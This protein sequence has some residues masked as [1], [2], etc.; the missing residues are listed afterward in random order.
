[1]A[2]VINDKNGLEKEVIAEIAK[3]LG[4]TPQDID[5]NAMLSDDL[6][7]G[8]VEMADLIGAISQKFD[9]NFN[10]SDLSSIKSVHDLVVSVEDLS[11]E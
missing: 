1:M 2:Q 6:G 8:P 3:H 5:V 4:V 11:L 10:P 9:V 7:L